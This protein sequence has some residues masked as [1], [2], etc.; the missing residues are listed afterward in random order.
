MDYAAA[1]GA[2]MRRRLLEEMYDRMT[3][4]ERRLFVRMAMEDRGSDEILEAI[5]ANQQ[6][7]EH[8]VDHIDRDR[9]YVSFG[10]DVAA[11]VL[12]GAGAW[13]LGKLLA[14]R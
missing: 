13:L 7:L 3:D 6:R 2:I 8:I 1:A 12:T 10:S 4:E 9:W 11:N 14:K 5:R